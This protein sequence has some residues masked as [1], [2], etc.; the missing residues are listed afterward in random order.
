MFLFYSIRHFDARLIFSSVV[1]ELMI[2]MDRLDGDS[3][4]KSIRLEIDRLG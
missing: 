4:T 3:E 1:V 2:A